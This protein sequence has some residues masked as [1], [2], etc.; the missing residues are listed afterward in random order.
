MPKFETFVKKVNGDTAVRKYSA[1][2]GTDGKEIPAG[3]VH[4]D[5][6]P[7]KVGDDWMKVEKVRKVT[8]AYKD[9]SYDLLMRVEEV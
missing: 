4:Y 7:S 9:K 1:F 2:P 3:E 5:F 6:D 8:F